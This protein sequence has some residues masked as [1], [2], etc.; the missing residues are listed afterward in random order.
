[1]GERK[2]LNHP[3]WECKCPETLIPMKLRR[4]REL[5]NEQLNAGWCVWELR[6]GARW[7]CFCLSTTRRPI[8]GVWVD[9]QR[10]SLTDSAIC[11]NNSPPSSPDWPLS[12]RLKV[13]TCPDLPVG[14]RS[15]TTGP[16]TL[17]VVLGGL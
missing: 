17:L 11:L 12:V 5:L 15:A 1:M 9:A 2:S 4:L 7:S 13:S 10:A 6:S 8:S 3:K 16:T 14:S